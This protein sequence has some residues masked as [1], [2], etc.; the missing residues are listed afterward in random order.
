MALPRIINSIESDTTC[1]SILIDKSITSLDVYFSKLDYDNLSPE[2]MGVVLA[3]GDVGV[4]NKALHCAHN[5]EKL[6]YNAD[7][8][9]K[10]EFIKHY[11][12]LAL[13]TVTESPI[14][15]DRAH[16]FQDAKFIVTFYKLNPILFPKIFDLALFTILIS[17]IANYDNYHFAKLEPEAKSLFY[18][19]S[20]LIGVE[21]KYALNLI[22]YNAPASQVLVQYS[23]GVLDLLFNFFT[24]RA[25]RN[26]V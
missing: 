10:V 14:A 21:K 3:L 23:F 19:M 20:I 11:I 7:M 1:K 24:T 13:N 25:L 26:H 17:S 9:A 22:Y 16:V 15:A 5:D 2:S 12:N 18:E 6:S 8:W 4:L